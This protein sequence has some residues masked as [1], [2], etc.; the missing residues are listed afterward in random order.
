MYDLV[1][2][3][4]G[5]A[6]VLHTKDFQRTEVTRLDAGRPAR[7]STAVRGCRGGAAVGP[8]GQPVV[9]R[10]GAGAPDRPRGAALP[11]DAV[12]RRRE[13]RTRARGR[14]GRHDVGGRRTSTGASRGSRP[15]AWSPCR[16]SRRR[17]VTRAPTS[18][19]SRAPPTA[20]CGS[21]TPTAAAWSACRSKA[22]CRW[23]RSANSNPRQ[24]RT[25]PRRR[26]VVL[27]P[28]GVVGHSG[29]ARHT[30]DG[31]RGTSPSRRDGT[32]LAR[33]RDVHAQARSAAA[34]VPAPLAGERAS[35]PARRSLYV[36]S[37]TRVFQG[38]DGGPCDD[39]PP[40]VTIRPRRPVAGR[41]QTRRAAGDR[42][43]ARPPRVLRRGAKSSSTRSACAAPAPGA[44]S[45]ARRRCAGSGTRRSFCFVLTATDADGYDGG[46]DGYIRLT[47][48]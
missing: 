39:T 15:P 37:A 3:P 32:V 34:P 43:R 1:A 23:S 48:R 47:T 17:R 33:G 11:R 44:S 26:R 29:G 42:E 10:A 27:R 12:P 16:R 46:T 30:V 2:D 5:G 41:V 25:G 14:S 38:L 9:R 6:W 13:H 7:A 18:P 40:K 36:A 19:T 31:R 45:R 20:P 28:D 22:R 4:A 21:P 24:A 8:D 35:T